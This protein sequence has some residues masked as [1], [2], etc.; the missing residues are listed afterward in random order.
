MRWPVREKARSARSYAVRTTKI[1]RKCATCG[2]VP[3]KL[4]N[5]VVE[6]L[7][8]FAT[9]QSHI[10]LGMNTEH[11]QLKERTYA[12]NHFEQR[13]PL[14]WRCFSTFFFFFFSWK[15]SVIRIIRYGHL[16]SLLRRG[17]LSASYI[18]I[19]LAHSAFLFLYLLSKFAQSHYRE[20]LHGSKLNKKKESYEKNRRIKTN[21][22][23]VPIVSRGE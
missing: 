4:Q 9:V 10:E 20:A 13:R 1:S 11:W 5:V 6:A 7:D 18:Y 2:V 3:K 23:S 8:S 22:V 15:I 21:F 17:C 14:S 19:V 16:L 12:A